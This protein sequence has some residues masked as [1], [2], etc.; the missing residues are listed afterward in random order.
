MQLRRDKRINWMTRCRRGDRTERLPSPMVIAIRHRH[1]VGACR[2]A[3]SRTGRRQHHHQQQPKHQWCTL[4][5]LAHPKGRS[6]HAEVLRHTY[7]TF[8]EG[9][10]EGGNPL[11]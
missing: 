4:M 5:G 2:T 1:L 3:L 10:Y 6:D 11:V 8:V 7:Y 9:R